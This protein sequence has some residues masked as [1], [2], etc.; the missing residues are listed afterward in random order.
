MLEALRAKFYQHTDLRD[1][2]VGTGN[3]E[4][5]EHTKSDKQWADGGDGKGKNML[6]ILLMKVRDELK[7]I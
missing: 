1:V 5:A 7:N 6:G 3:R 2:L 4:L